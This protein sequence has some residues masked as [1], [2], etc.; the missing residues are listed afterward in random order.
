MGAN[1]TIQILSNI[2]LRTYYVFT[3]QRIEQ[4]SMLEMR[5]YK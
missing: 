5:F 3:V 1:I 4:Q 2:I